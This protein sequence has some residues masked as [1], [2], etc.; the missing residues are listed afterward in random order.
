MGSI[1]VIDCYRLPEW[2]DVDET[3]VGEREALYL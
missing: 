1:V 2:E 3:F